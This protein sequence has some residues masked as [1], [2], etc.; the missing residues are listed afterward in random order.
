MKSFG[1]L[2]TILA[3]IATLAAIFVVA[4]PTLLGYGVDE[5]FW[6]IWGKVY[7]GDHIRATVTVQ[8]QD[9]EEITH[10]LDVSQL[11]VYES[12]LEPESGAHAAELPSA[13]SSQGK[14]RTLTA[15]SSRVW[16]FAL[17]SG[18]DKA[19]PAQGTSVYFG[20]DAPEKEFVDVRLKL[21]V[22]AQDGGEP[23]VR[24][25]VI[26]ESRS[27][28][29]VR[30]QATLSADW[31]ETLILPPAEPSGAGQGADAGES[32]TQAREDTAEEEQPSSEE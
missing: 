12:A 9:L 7:R 32:S 27:P 30:E 6:D 24:A 3:V 10:T 15:N 26:I 4:C 2:M 17:D 13:G 18:V 21:L 22:E 25:Q 16:R 31:G 20:V 19:L 29:S 23:R 28:N 14:A 5:L 1:R 8:Y 11:A